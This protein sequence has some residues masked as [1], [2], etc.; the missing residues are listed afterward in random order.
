MESHQEV[1]I[2]N[3]SPILVKWRFSSGW[4]CQRVSFRM[5]KY[6]IQSIL[7]NSNCVRRNKKPTTGFDN[8]KPT[9]NNQKGNGIQT[10]LINPMGM[11][12]REVQII[13]RWHVWKLICFHWRPTYATASSLTVT[14]K[15]MSGKISCRKSGRMSKIWNYNCHWWNSIVWWV[16]NF[17]L[18]AIST[19]HRLIQPL[20]DH[21]I[22]YRRR[23]SFNR[24]GAPNIV[25]GKPSAV[26]FLN[27]PSYC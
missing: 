4:Y 1:D 22:N 25:L 16:W 6:W 11:S 8:G 9:H 2:V 21:S 10:G 26:Y 5:G 27:R 24:S 3:C 13:M 18:K 15:I 23:K 17:F 12:F 19:D 7:N 14:R 20:I